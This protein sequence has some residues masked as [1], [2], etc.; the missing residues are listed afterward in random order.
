MLWLTKLSL[1]PLK[2]KIWS[3]FC[4]IFHVSIH[5][6]SKV[7]FHLFFNCCDLDHCFKYPFSSILETPFFIKSIQNKGQVSLP[8]IIFDLS[9]RLH[10]SV[11]ISFLSQFIHDLFTA[12]W[13]IHY[14][15]KLHSY[16]KNLLSWGYSFFHFPE[17]INQIYFHWVSSLLKVYLKQTTSNIELNRK[18]CWG[19]IIIC[20]IPIPMDIECK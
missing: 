13:L 11:K 2:I 14:W 5:F 16:K 20:R 19:F 3:L 17:Q 4:F 10:I 12:F 1:P 15:K 6:F 9:S 7:N 8:L 18:K